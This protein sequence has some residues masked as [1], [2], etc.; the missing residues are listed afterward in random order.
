M[1]SIKIGTAPIFGENMGAVPIVDPA[2][3]Q[4]FCAKTYIIF[5]QIRKYKKEIPATNPE[6]I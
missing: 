6:T 2:I 4:L 1:S 3:C 5:R